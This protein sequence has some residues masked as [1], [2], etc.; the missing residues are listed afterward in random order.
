[1]VNYFVKSLNL[2]YLY[3]YVVYICIYI[4]LYSIYEVWFDIFLGI[5]RYL[6]KIKNIVLLF[7]FFEKLGYRKVYILIYKKCYIIIGMYIKIV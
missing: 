7:D 6:Y 4:Y 1:M 2:V 5:K 3:I